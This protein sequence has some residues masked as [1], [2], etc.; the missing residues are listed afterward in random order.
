MNRVS[1]QNCR[2]VIALASIR[3]ALEDATREGL[4]EAGELKVYETVW[5]S[6]AFTL[7]EL[8]VGEDGAIEGSRFTRIAKLLLRKR[9]GA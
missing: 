6:G 4:L 8:K 1:S 9:L 5:R 7:E 2:E 3:R